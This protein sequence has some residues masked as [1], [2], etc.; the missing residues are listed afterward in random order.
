MGML[1]VFAGIASLLIFVM[2]SLLQAKSIA[3]GNRYICETIEAV[4]WKANGEFT[5]LD[6]TK[7]ETQYIIEPEVEN[8]KIPKS[9]K[10]GFFNKVST[11]SISLLGADKRLALCEAASWSAFSL[12]CHNPHP[13][14]KDGAVSSL[15]KF[16]IALSEDGRGTFA[17]NFTTSAIYSNSFQ[18]TTFDFPALEVGECKQF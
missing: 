17:K 2:P 10:E 9:S 3:D 5:D 18:D 13:V 6:I 12:E 16:F 11:H 7:P 15:P 8:F 1:K 4:G 14:F